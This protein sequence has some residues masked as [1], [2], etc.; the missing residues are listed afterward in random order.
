MP[1]EHRRPNAVRH[2]GDDVLRA[3]DCIRRGG[4]GAREARQGDGGAL[5]CNRGWR[6]AA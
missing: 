3:P 6:I 5:H 1:P 2:V 4:A